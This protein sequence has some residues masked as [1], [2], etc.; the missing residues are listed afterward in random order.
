MS[1]C[2]CPDCGAIVEHVIF[3]EEGFGVECSKCGR[4][5]LMEDEDEE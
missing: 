5:I 2:R 4:Q 3:E 1:C